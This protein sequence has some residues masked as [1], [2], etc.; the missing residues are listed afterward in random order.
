MVELEPLLKAVTK[1]SPTPV[2]ITHLVEAR[3]SR[4]VLGRRSLPPVPAV[5]S[6]DTLRGVAVPHQGGWLGQASN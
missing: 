2:S 6:L 5:A 1:V 4:D 3:P